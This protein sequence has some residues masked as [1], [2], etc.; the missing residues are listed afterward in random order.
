MRFPRGVA[1][2]LAL[3]LGN[4]YGRRCA[5]LMAV[6]LVT[7][8]TTEVIKASVVA[9]LANNYRSSLHWKGMRLQTE[10][11][12]RLLTIF[13]KSVSANAL[14]RRVAAVAESG[15]ERAGMDVEIPPLLG[16]RRIT[17]WERRER[18]ARRW[19]REQEASEHKRTMRTSPE[20]TSAR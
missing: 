15:Q 4:P 12:M 3:E 7:V 13:P 5:L 17:R 14:M 11:H 16:P 20:R 2:T 9:P 18:D 1:P 8:Q 10:R 6:H 19:D